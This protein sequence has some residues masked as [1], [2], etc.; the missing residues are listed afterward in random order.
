MTLIEAEAYGTPVFFCDPD[1]RE[2]VPKNSFIES[3]GKSSGKMAEA[4]NDLIEHPEKI[5]TMSEIMLKHREE[6]LISNRIKELER[7]FRALLS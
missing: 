3:V 1:M 2:V 7:I 4:L 6:V 5:Q